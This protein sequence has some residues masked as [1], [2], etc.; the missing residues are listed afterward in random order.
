MSNP[1]ALTYKATKTIVITATTATTPI[2]VGGGNQ[3]RL[4]NYSSGKVAYCF[5]AAADI[6]LDPTLPAGGF[7]IVTA[8]G[9]LSVQAE[10]ADGSFEC[11]PC[12]GV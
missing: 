3:Y 12:V 8:S 2:P 4:V 1:I 5:G 10:T 9:T 11:T 7:E 6:A